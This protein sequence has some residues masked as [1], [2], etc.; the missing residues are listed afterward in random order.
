MRKNKKLWASAV[1]LPAVIMLSGCFSKTDCN[2]STNKE[3]ALNIIAAEL[4]KSKWFR[5]MKLGMSESFSLENIRMSSQSENGESASCQADY[6]FTYN[7]KSKSFSVDYDLNYLQDKGIAEVSVYTAPLQAQLIGLATT[8][9]PIKNGEDIR[10]DPASGQPLAKYF[11]KDN[12]LDGIAE[13]YDPNTHALT[14]QINYVNGKKSGVEKGWAPDGRQQLVEL[15]WIDGKATGY[16]K[17]FFDG[18]LVADIRWENGLQTGFR[19]DYLG[20]HRGYDETNYDKGKIV[21]G[22]KSFAYDE[23]SGKYYLTSESIYDANGNKIKF[24]RFSQDSGKVYIEENYDADGKSHGIFSEY[25][26]DGSVV[27]ARHY[28]HGTL[29]Q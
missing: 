29:I 26:E 3:T 1:L 10:L 16:E 7:G 24:R 25:N 19:S 8:E 22:V 17:K 21:G 12:Q 18:K 15:N 6:T 13:L 4:G 14:A 20:G 9:A 28:E 11:W 2:D 23:Y 27:S 5:E